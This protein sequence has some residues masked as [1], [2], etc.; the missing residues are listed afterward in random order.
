MSDT[1]APGPEDSTWD[2]FKP[3]ARDGASTGSL[4]AV[5]PAPSPREPKRRRLPRAVRGVLLT[6]A[7]VALVAV[8]VG[9]QWWD[10]SAWVAERYPAEVVKDVPRGQSVVLHGMRWQVSLAPGPRSN[11][12]AAAA[13]V[14]TVQVTPVSAGEIAGYRT[15]DFRTRGRTG[16]EW[17]A[18]PAGT[19]TS[20]D[21]KVGRTSR[22]TVVTAVPSALRDTAELVLSYSPRETLRFAR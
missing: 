2:A 1:Y 10:R 15:P 17:E 11:D 21:L 8:T 7:A 13:L 19:P 6:L 16:G 5:P 3:V 22:F 20:S 12:P 4:P 9:V 18:V 14:A